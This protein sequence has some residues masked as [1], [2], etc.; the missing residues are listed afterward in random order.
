MAIPVITT[1]HRN[2]WAECVSHFCAE[3]SKLCPV[4]VFWVLLLCQS[5]QL[6]CFQDVQSHLRKL[7]LGFSIKKRKG[8]KKKKNQRILNVSLCFTVC[9]EKYRLSP[10]QTSEP[11]L[12]PT[13]RCPAIPGNP[14]LLTNPLPKVSPPRARPR[15]RI[16]LSTLMSPSPLSV[17]NLTSGGL[18]PA[19]SPDALVL[20]SPLGSRA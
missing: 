2:T 6:P 16:I 9:Q 13:G 12:L 10:A 1:S 5:A 11:G 20:P 18:Q 17:P 14:L 4:L 3:T 7:S 19:H 15:K 8:V